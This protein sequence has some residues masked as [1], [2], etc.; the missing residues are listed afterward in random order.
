MTTIDIAGTSEPALAVRYTVEELA[1]IADLYDLDALPGL[2]PVALS[3]EARGLATRTLL[4]RDVL[5]I[6]NDDALEVTQPHATFLAALF[7]APVVLQVS[8]VASGE[9][10]TSAWFDWGDECV[11]VHPEDGGTVYVAAYKG[12]ARD[13]VLSSLHA[14][15]ISTD[16]KD[17]EVDLV[18]EIV[19]TTRNGD[20]FTIEQE[21]IGR[22][23]AQWYQ[24]HR[25]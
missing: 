22:C 24:V 4:A 16:V 11:G 8:Q 25:A 10:L 21:A 2:T 6:R 23:E 5:F 14:E 19:T 15:T 12:C 20:E 17:V 3:D 7:E 1:V 13:I 9:T 18:V